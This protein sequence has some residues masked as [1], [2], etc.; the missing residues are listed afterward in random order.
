[1]HYTSVRIRERKGRGLIAEASYK[2]EATGK[3]RKVSTGLEATGKRAAQKEAEAWLSEI[4]AEWQRKQQEASALTAL[5]LDA[6]AP[7]TVSAY[8]RRYLD[9]KRHEIEPSTFNGYT[10]YL[11]KQIAPT[12]GDV[13]L[14]KL[15]PDTVRAW[16]AK[17]S[18]G[19]SAVTVRKSLT[20]LRS[21]M[22]EAINSDLLIKDPTRGVKAPKG[23]RP[24][25][26]ALTVE[27]VRTV[28]A[29][30][31]VLDLTPQLLGIKIALFTGMREAE[32][33]A[34]RWSNVDIERGTLYVDEALGRDGAAYYLKDAKTTDSARYVT[35]GN[36]LADDLRARREQME[37][38][39][40]AAGV[41]FDDRFFV[42]GDMRGGFLRP[43]YLGN[44]WREL[45]GAIE[46]KG[47][48]GT[49]PTFHDLRHTFATI[50]IESGVDVKAVSAMLGHSNAAMTLNTY[51]DATR[52]GKRRAALAVENALTV[53]GGE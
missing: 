46:I 3:W 53:G 31:D 43:Q 44:K 10:R 2:D 5:G 52:E 11:D 49:R 36:A 4:E 7:L 8:V 16:V 35:F 32:I 24:K 15:N 19:Y 45:A 17:L 22:N 18:E 6:D 41:P 50:A 39:C 14:S 34:L 26:N 27:G 37:A 51:A 28:L 33:C 30:L 23:T 42:L 38:D 9:G 12:L 47:T 21:A 13:E 40:R 29:V 20:L 25:P 1:M 48:Q